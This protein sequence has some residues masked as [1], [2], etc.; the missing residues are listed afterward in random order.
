MKNTTKLF[1]IIALVAVIAFT[2]AACNK[3]S[4]GSAAPAATGGG[5]ADPAPAAAPAPAASSA[6][7]SS[8]T[9]DRILDDYEEFAE[10]YASLLQK[11][12]SGDMAA[13][14]E[15]EALAERAE[16]WASQ[17][18]GYSESD[19][20][21]AQAIRLGQIIEKFSGIGF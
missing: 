19:L 13:M 6:S 20:S 17:W 2:M 5:A 8:N 16:T 12:M 1:G 3:G 21:P 18:E 9:I 15:F 11:V 4:S 14:T 7:G 10:E